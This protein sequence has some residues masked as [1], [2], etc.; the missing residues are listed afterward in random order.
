MTVDANG[1]TIPVFTRNATI[2]N[3]ATKTDAIDLGSASFVGITLPAEFDGSTLTFEVSDSLTGTFVPFAPTLSGTAGA[4]K[5]MEF[6]PAVFAGVRFMKVVAGAQT[7][8]TVLKLHLR[9]I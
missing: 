4:S 3:A 5:Y 8:A 7:G 9:R 6:N 1:F 2:A